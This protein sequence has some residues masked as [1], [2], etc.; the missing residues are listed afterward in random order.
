MTMDTD[1]LGIFTAQ[2]NRIE[3]KTEQTA[4]TTRQIARAVFGEILAGH[5]GLVDDVKEL[6]KFK[7]DQ[8]AKVLWMSGA[9]AGAVA[10]VG[11]GFKAIMAKLFGQQ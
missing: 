10:A 9:V 3:S 8:N 5:S 6:K 2:L 1:Q 4:E 7:D 11:L